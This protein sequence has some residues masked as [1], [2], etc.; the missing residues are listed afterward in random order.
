MTLR[1]RKEYL[2]DLE[3][4]VRDFA[5]H[6][7][8]PVSKVVIKVDGFIWRDIQLAMEQDRNNSIRYP[9]EMAAHLGI[10]AVEVYG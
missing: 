6:G 3:G 10:L 2:Q 1:T 4:A 7:G 8:I 9:E 5:R